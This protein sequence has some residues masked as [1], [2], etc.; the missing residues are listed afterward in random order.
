MVLLPHVYGHTPD[1]ATS[2]WKHP[3][4]ADKSIETRD[5]GAKMSNNE[6]IYGA[7]RKQIIVWGR[8]TLFAAIVLA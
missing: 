6:E 2:T 3:V 5:G 8:G 4:F 1:S 7:F